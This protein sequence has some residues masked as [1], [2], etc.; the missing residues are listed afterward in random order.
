MGSEQATQPDLALPS[1]LPLPPPPPHS[2]LLQNIF[3]RLLALTLLLWL[4]QELWDLKADLG[5]A[6]VL[7]SEIHEI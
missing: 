1:T 2:N 5:A 6:L 3:A 4:P 7:K